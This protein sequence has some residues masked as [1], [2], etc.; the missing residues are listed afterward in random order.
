M[1]VNGWRK[2]FGRV[3]VILSWVIVG[4]VYSFIIIDSIWSQQEYSIIDDNW[5]GIGM[6]IIAVIFA[7][8]LALHLDNHI[9]GL[10]AWMNKHLDKWWPKKSQ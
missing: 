3:V 9:G 4:F 1:A 6:F 2:L 8:I 7:A 10:V 5:Q